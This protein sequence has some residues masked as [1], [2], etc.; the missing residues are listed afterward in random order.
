M[1]KRLDELELTVKNDVLDCMVKSEATLDL[2][3][4]N[5]NDACELAVRKFL[6]EELHINNSDAMP[7]VRCHRMHERRN[8]K[9]K[10]IIVRFCRYRDREIV[11]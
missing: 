2:A 6:K 8:S 10:Q 11:W 3:T 7:F 9:I 1:V 4:Q 5:C